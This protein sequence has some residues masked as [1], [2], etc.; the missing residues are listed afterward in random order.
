MKRKFKKVQHR[1]YLYIVRKYWIYLHELKKQDWRTNHWW[2]CLSWFTDNVR[3]SCY[4]VKVKMSKTTAKLY[5]K[6]RN[7]RRSNSFQLCSLWSPCLFK[8]LNSKNRIW[9]HEISHRSLIIAR[10]SESINYRLIDG[11]FHIALVISPRPWYRPKG[12]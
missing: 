1:H 3:I 10:L 12:L 9:N 6:S 4:L 11:L 7:Q 5:K 2:V 8:Q